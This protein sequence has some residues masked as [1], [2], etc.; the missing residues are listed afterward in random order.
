MSCFS[1]FCVPFHPFLCATSAIFACHFSHFC[2]PF[3]PFLRT[4]SAIF[5]CRVR[6]ASS[7]G[8]AANMEMARHRHAGASAFRCLSGPNE[9]IYI[10]PH[11]SAIFPPS[12]RRVFQPLADVCAVFPA[13]LA[14]IMFIFALD[15][16]PI[17]RAAPGRPL[18]TEP[19]LGA[20]T[21]SQGHRG[22]PG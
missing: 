7:R 2:V 15:G 3:Q 1:H 9:M 21:R 6:P 19:I 5:A 4:I 13:P 10:F 20:N 18:S 17:W 14:D 8:I 16:Q 11:L 12:R 22:H